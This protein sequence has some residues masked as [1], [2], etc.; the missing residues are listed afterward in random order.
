MIWPTST[1]LKFE[2]FTLKTEV[3]QY[4]SPSQELPRDI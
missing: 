1:R 2:S 3:G 4:V